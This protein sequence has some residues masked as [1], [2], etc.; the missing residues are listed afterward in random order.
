MPA[1]AAAHR[2]RSTQP[3]PA[4]AIVCSSDTLA[5]GALRALA[6]RGLRAGPDVAV[7]GFDNTPVAAAVRPSV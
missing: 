5:L 2:A 6:T 4:T 3:D 7:T 1:G